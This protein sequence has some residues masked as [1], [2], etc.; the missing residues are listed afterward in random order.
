M[1]KTMINA[2][3]ALSF[4]LA[5][6]GAQAATVGLGD[7]GSITAGV[8][9]YDTLGNA[10]NVSSGS[11]FGMDTD[12]NGKI[13][14]T[15][16]T[17]I[18]QGTAG[19]VFGV[20]TTAGASHSG[21]PTAGDTNKIDA[22]WAFFGNTGSDY[23]N[24]AIAGST[25]SGVNMSGWTVTWNGIPA[26]N[27]GGSAWGTG[28]TSGVGNLVWNGVN[29]G[30]YTLDYHATVPLGDPSGF[31]GVQ[32]ALHLTGTVSTVPVPA[33]AWLMGSGLVGLVGVARRKKQA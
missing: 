1:K 11:Y 23:N 30:A 21:A 3:L 12:H 25:T 2:A 16:K 26:I 22:P 32:Y 5:A 4:G 20:T 8:Y 10:S 15:E 31:G 33:A 29:H 27:M 19:L 28:F 14:G 18:S 6:G 7:T 13:S 17:A 9:A 24:V